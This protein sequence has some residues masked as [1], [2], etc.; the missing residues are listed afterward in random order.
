MTGPNVPYT[1]LD[2]NQVLRQSFDESEDRLRVDATFS[3]DPPPS[4]DITLTPEDDAVALGDVSGNLVTTTPGD[5]PDHIGLDV[6]VL[7]QIEGHFQPTG[8]SNGIKTT[9]IMVTDVPTKLPATAMVLRNGISVR[10]WGTNIVYVGGST[11]TAINGYPKM[12]FEEIQMDI[13]DNSLVEL[14]GICDSGKTCEV[15]VIEVG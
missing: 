5:D 4:M 10:I 6:N 7:N 1:D 2:A 13:T 14:Y 3:M 9:T 12:Q 8:L 11:V 15:R